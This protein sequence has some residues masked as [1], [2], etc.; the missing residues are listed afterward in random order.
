MEAGWGWGR[1]SR[2]GGGERREGNGH[3]ERE[4]V[5][6]SALLVSLSSFRVLFFRFLLMTFTINLS[7]A[8]FLYGKKPGD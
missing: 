1:S 3:D 2:L 5:G 8:C 6:R 7:R 4:E